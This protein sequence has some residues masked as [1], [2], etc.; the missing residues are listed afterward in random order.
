MFEQVDLQFD[1]RTGRAAGPSIRRYQ[2]TMSKRRLVAQCVLSPAICVT[3]RSPVI[4]AA[5]AS[6]KSNGLSSQTCH[7]QSYLEHVWRFQDRGDDGDW[8]MSD[9]ASRR[10]RFRVGRL[11][12]KILTNRCQL[13][14]E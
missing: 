13:N 6:R 8:R 10:L 2:V 1:R 14:G 7:G 12:C 3:G 11:A 5:N 4:Y 9:A